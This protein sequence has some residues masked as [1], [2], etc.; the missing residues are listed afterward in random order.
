MKLFSKKAL[1]VVSM[2]IATAIGV[3]G[4]GG[5]GGSSDSGAKKFVNIATGGTAGTYY[6]LGGAIAEILNKAIPI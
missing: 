3:A 4:C 1:V 5:S 2:C 6:P